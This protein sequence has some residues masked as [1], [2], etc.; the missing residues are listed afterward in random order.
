MAAPSIQPSFRAH[1]IRY[2]GSIAGRDRILQLIQYAARFMA[3]KLARAKYSPQAV[4]KYDA[5][6]RQI[7][8]TRKLWRVGR[9][10]DLLNGVYLS[11]PRKAPANPISHYLTL[12]RQLS[13]ASYLFIDSCTAVDAIGLVKIRSMPRLSRMC[14]Q[15]WATGLVFGISNGLYRVAGILRARARAVQ[16][17][18]D[19]KGGEKVTVQT[20]SPTSVVAATPIVSAEEQKAVILQ[21]SADIA[22]FHVAS[23]ALNLHGLNDGVVSVAGMWSSLIGIYFQWRQTA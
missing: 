1:Y 15:L 18:P 19:G 12:G 23:S 10:I 16:S 13:L 20:T 8:L 4:E 22:D 6:K 5:I 21:L 14:I 17:S 11:L 3:W 7:I 9:F 2:S